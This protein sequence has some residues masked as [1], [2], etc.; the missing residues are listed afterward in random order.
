MALCEHILVACE[1]TPEGDEALVAASALARRCGARL[2]LVAVAQTDPPA[3]RR[4][5]GAGS[6]AWNRC[7]RGDARERLERGA[8][9]VTGGPEPD[10]AVVE[11]RPATALAIVAE[12]QDCDLIVVPAPPSGRLA[13]L[14]RRDWTVALRRRA[15]VPVLQ[16]PSGAARRRSG[17]AAATPA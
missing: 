12:E 16:T 3:A 17:R 7:E 9:M 1:A 8:L 6:G 15:S 11:G 4:C 2:T 5:C 13:R 14:L 10:L